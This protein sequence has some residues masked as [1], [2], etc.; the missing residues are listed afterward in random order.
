MDTTVADLPA[1]TAQLSGSRLRAALIAG[2]RRVLARREHLN[3]INVFP[4]PDGDTGTNLAFTLAAV[5]GSARRGRGRGVGELLARVARDAVDDARGNSGAIFAQFFQGLAEALGRR[6]VADAAALAEATEAAARSARGALAQPRE[7]TILSVI[8]DFA[9][10]LRRQAERGVADL[11]ALFAQALQRARQSLQDTPRQLPVLRAAGVVDA[12]AAGFVDFLEG[13]QEWLECGRRA[14]RLPAHLRRLDA[15]SGADTV[16]LES[17][18]SDS[19]YRYCSECVLTGEELE[20]ANI[21]RHLES[22]PLDSLVVA[23]GTTR[24]RV[25]AHTDDPNRLFQAL[26]AFGKVSQRKADDM[27]AQARLRAAAFQPVR[28]ICDSAA[29][30]PPAEIER[31]GIGIVPVRVIDGEEDFLD[32]VTLSAQELYARLRRDPSPL[33]TS[34]PPAADFRR[35][36]ELTL[37]HCEHVVSLSLTGKASGTCQAAMAAARD[38]GRGR[39][40]VID[41]LTVSCGEALVVLRAAEVAADGAGL[42]TVCATARQAMAETRVWALIPDLRY[43]VAGGRMPRLLGRLADLFGLHMMVT[44]RDGRVRPCGALRGRDGLM[45]RFARS[46]ARRLRGGGGWRAIVAH[47]DAAGAAA[48]LAAALRER[49]A[50]LDKVWVTECGPALGCHAGPGT[51]VVGLQPLPRSS[52]A[53][54]A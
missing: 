4:V 24:L 27:Q 31:L 53:G 26:A 48:T 38:S 9:G 8:S 37:S 22:L 10:E 49:I 54:A 23:G 33:R 43:A 28:V 42:E 20:P 50:A 25:H 40:H 5:L 46:V 19:H 7:G 2:C 11:R 17:V 52:K 12:G 15:E 45:E 34:Q 36:Y 35:A 51:V 41:T 44:V 6:T 32:R 29:D 30:L 39:V 16:H 18:E 13:V 14:L 3:R 1:V 21:R 47:C